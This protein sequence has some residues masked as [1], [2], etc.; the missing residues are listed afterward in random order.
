MGL[1]SES[2]IGQQKRGVRHCKEGVV[3]ARADQQKVGLARPGSEGLAS[4]SEWQGWAG[5][6]QHGPTTGHPQHGPTTGQH[7]PTQ[8]GMDHSNWQPAR[9]PG[10]KR[11][12]VALLGDPTTCV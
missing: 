5:M 3:L 1:A 12:C 11:L 6:D 10:S 7:S 8:F 2:R 9:S 4:R